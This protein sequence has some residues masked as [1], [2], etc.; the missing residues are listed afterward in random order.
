VIHDVAGV[1]SR[2]EIDETQ[3]VNWRFI[4]NAIATSGEQ[5]FPCWM[6]DGVGM[7]FTSAPAQPCPTPRP[8]TVPAVA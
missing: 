6:S 5:C 4:A 3:E 8:G 7:S 1:P 2:G